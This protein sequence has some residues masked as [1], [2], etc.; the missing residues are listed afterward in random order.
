MTNITIYL[1]NGKSSAVFVIL[2][3]V[4]AFA[5]CRLT[6]VLVVTTKSPKILKNGIKIIVP[7]TLK[8]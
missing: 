3:I 2:K 1:L 7:R 4:W 8:V 6:S 5:I